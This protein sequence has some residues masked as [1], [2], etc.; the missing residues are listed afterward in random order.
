M[1][2]YLA[3]VS[4]NAFLCFWGDLPELSTLGKQCGQ[5]MGVVTPAH[6][7]WGFDIRQPSL[8]SKQDQ[9]PTSLGR[10]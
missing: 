1:S 4:N 7:N 10:M 3:T 6:D 8:I 9:Y 5:D 2:C